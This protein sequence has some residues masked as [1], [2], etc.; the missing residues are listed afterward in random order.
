MV[1][2]RRPGCPA[3]RGLAY[4]A[5]RAPGPRHRVAP[6]A[7]GAV[8]PRGRGA[9]RPSPL[10]DP[11]PRP[12]HR[13]LSESDALAFGSIE[14]VELGRIRVGAA[15][16]LRGELPAGFAVKRAPSRPA[17]LAVGDRVLLLLR[18]A[19]SPYLLVEAPD[20]IWRLAAPEDEPALATA[21][22]AL[23]AA[24]PRSEDVAV[25]YAKWLR[26]DAPAL[27]HFAVQGFAGDPTLFRDALTRDPALRELLVALAS[28]ALDEQ[29]R[30]AA[31]RA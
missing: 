26:A 20:E 12:L 15:V 8:L 22:R 13:R 27:V 7:V 28:D 31:R 4:A 23:D 21:I 19:R 5:P 1:P 6:R 14:Q 3:R 11:G 10:E 17:P 18:G 29:V 25:L 16:A 2:P 24:T 9:A 30:L